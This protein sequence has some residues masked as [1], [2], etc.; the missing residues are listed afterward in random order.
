MCMLQHQTRPPTN[1]HTDMLSLLCYMY[2][3]LD[4]DL[5]SMQ[6]WLKQNSTESE[7]RN[8]AKFMDFVEEESSDEES[9]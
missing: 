8:C 1:I 9:E 2:N 4:F 7:L 3:I 5:V 6:N